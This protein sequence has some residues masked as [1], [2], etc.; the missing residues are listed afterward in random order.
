ME[1]AAV[2][3]LILD[4]FELLPDSQQLCMFDLPDFSYNRCKSPKVFMSSL[5]G[6]I[7]KPL[8]Y[9]AL[10]VNIPK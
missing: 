2:F 4:L 5:D 8:H 7:C 10:I 6:P 9:G 1:A 3:A